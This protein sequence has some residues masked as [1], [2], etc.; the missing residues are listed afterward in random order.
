MEGQGQPFNGDTYL[1]KEFL[2]LKRDFKI[3]N[4]VE[5]GTYHGDSTAW[6]AANFLAVQ[7]IEFKMPQYLEAKKKLAALKNVSMV[8]GDSA[9]DLKTMIEGQ[10]NLLIFLDAHWYANPVIDELKQIAA[11]GLKPVIAIHDF[12]V[13]KKDFG[14]DSYNGQDY[15][16][17]WVEPHLKAIYGEF[18]YHYNT[19]AT[20]AMRGCLFVYPKKS[21]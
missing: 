4:V 5:T 17:E 11:C 7:T 3:K 2:R 14:F 18:D 21:L 15:T 6:F 8:R 13:P 10:P 20:G 19:E 9:R 16:F 12:K 1:E